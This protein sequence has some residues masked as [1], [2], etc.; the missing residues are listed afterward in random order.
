[1]PLYKYKSS[2]PG[3]SCMKCEK[4]L[5]KMQTMSDDALTHCP[6]CGGPIQRIIQS[7]GIKIPHSMKVRVDYRDDLARYPGDPTAWVDGPRALSKLMDDRKR[8]GW[9]MKPLEMTS[10]TE[11][12]KGTLAAEAYKR[13]KAKGFIPDAERK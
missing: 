10:K 2:M 7:C 3:L 5:V 1:M 13:A 12:P 11:A 4:G 6:D 9:E 8:M